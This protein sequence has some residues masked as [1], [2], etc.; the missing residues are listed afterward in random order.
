LPP[1][2]AISDLG[3]LLYADYGYVVR[4]VVADEEM[5]VENY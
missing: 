4:I 1:N 5:E 3:Q 2:P